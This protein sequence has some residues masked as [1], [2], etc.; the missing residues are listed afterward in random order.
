KT[1]EQLELRS[2]MFAEISREL[3]AAPK[4]ELAE[5]WFRGMDLRLLDRTPL[6]YH[7]SCNRE[8]MERALLA[9]GRN[10]LQEII[11]DGKG[12]ELGCHFCHKTYF[13]TTQQLQ[14][15]IGGNANV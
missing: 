3:N 15:L 4:E 13:F 9:I 6:R 2:P 11:D 8:R 1:I 5:G 14:A 10:D 7:C 12:A